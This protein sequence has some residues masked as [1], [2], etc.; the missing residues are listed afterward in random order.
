MI[1]LLVYHNLK[2]WEGLLFQ[3]MTK[4]MLYNGYVFMP[5]AAPKHYPPFALFAA[6]KTTAKQFIPI[7]FVIKGSYGCLIRTSTK[8]LVHT[9]TKP[10]PYPSI[11][12][13]SHYDDDHEEIG[14]AV[15]HTILRFSFNKCRIKNFSTA[16]SSSIFFSEIPTAEQLL[17]FHCY[18]YFELTIFLGSRHSNETSFIIL[19]CTFIW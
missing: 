18:A 15:L 16:L 9:K 7:I 8:S 10:F 12:A 1:L 19:E 17:T 3:F 5:S 11:Y 2:D 13:W 6:E 4:S 14:D